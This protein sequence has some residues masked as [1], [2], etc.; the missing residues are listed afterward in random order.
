MVWSNERER[1]SL[2]KCFKLPCGINIYYSDLL[3]R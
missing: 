3:H 1:E 2:G